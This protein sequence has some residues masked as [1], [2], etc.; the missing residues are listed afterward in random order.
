[1]DFPNEG[2]V[3]QVIEKY[4]LDS[5]YRSLDPGYTDLIVQHEETREKWVV[6][7][8]GETSSIGLD[9]RTGLG[10]LIQRMEDSKVNY[11]IAVPDIPQFNK[12]YKLVSKRIRQLLNLYILLVSNDGK[13]KVIK[14]DNQI[15]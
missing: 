8:K 5:K 13:V 3:Q 11:A 15:E 6:E 9:F 7:A 2:F 1:M 12:Q 10:Q 4:F 14:P